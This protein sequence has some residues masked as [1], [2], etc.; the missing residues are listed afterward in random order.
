ML[1]WR[2]SSSF[3]FSGLFAIVLL[4]TQLAQAH[5]IWL[6]PEKAEGETTVQA[7]FGEDASPD[8]P[9]F[10]KYAQG[11]NAWVVDEKN[12][13]TPVEFRLDDESLSAKLDSL[14]EKGPVIVATHDLGVMDRGDA[15][16]RLKYYAKSGPHASAKAWSQIDTSKQ[17][18]LDTIPEV[19]QD[20]LRLHVLFDREAVSGSEVTASGP[21]L[22]HFEGKTG[23]SGT[24]DLPIKKSGLYSIRAKHVEAVPGEVDGKE[25]PETR[26]YT[27]LTLRVQ[28][29]LSPAGLGES[30]Q[31][32]EQPVT[33]FGGAI[34]DNHVF[35]YGGHTGS[36]HSY[37]KEEQDN[38]L[39]A[40][41]LQTGKWKTLAQGP[42]LQGLA[43]VAHDDKL[44]RI[45]GFT[46]MNAEGEEH[47]LWSQDSVSA[48]DLKT[49]EWIDLPS[50]PEPRSSFD[51]AVLDGKV[52]VIGGW[53]MAGEE[54]NFWHKT[55]WSLDLTAENPAWEALPNPPFQRRALAVAAH[56]GKIYVIGGMQEKGGPTTRVD[57]FDP[58][59]NKWTRGADLVMVQEESESEGRFSGGMTGFGAAAFATG[60]RLYASTIKGE[61]QRLSEDG[62]EWEIIGQTPTPRFFHRML[63]VSDHQLLVVGG[64]SMEIGKF[65]EIEILD[66]EEN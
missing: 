10:L 65:E 37:S 64:A 31:D 17:L 52:Y 39:K 26:H 5:F 8:D 16:F 12:N 15:K 42:H 32:L 33:S 46:A 54:E 25:Y 44:V 45:G 2:L 23:E 38:S 55:A 9:S 58:E 47:D 56:Q 49:N 35:L 43:L 27:T 18:R 36:A 1:S 66:V 20:G 60:G 34:L 63:P 51:A 59:T 4:S 62:S 14:S 3:A 21:D 41:D 30:L 24:V 19:T 53:K 22:I 57:V 13:A 11:M 40:L 48:F 61:L 28:S 50:L 7:Y 29:D 6:V